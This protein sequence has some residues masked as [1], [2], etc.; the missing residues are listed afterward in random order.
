MTHDEMIDA[1]DAAPR[2]ANWNS[3]GAKPVTDEAKAVARSI[4][5]LL[6]LDSRVGPT[7]DG[8][9]G[10]EWD[11]MESSLIVSI[12]DRGGVSVDWYDDTL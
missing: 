8:G 1:I 6:T 4:A 11:D 9:I 10:F 3:Y 12:N 7:P 5:R 2:D